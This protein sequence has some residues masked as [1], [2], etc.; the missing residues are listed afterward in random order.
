M[1]PKKQQA[2]QT[3]AGKNPMGAPAAPKMNAS[4]AAAGPVIS[5]NEAM[6]IAESTGKTTAQVM[7]KAVSQGAALGAA[8]VNSFNNNK[9]GPNTYSP[10]GGGNSPAVNKALEQLQALQGLQMNKGTAYAGYS[11]TS[12]P[13][14]TRYDGDGGALQIPGGT[15]FNPIVLP[16]NVISG[17]QRV[18]AGK[19]AAAPAAPAA[20]AEQPKDPYQAWMDSVNA[21]NQAIIDSVNKQIEANASQAQLYMGQIESLMAEMSKAQQQPGGLAS[22]T[23]YA[24]T[25]TT[26]PAAGAKLTTAITARK[27]PSETDLSISPLV[28]NLEGT[29]LNIAI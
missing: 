18:P 17:V 27:K 1:A 2:A 29:G 6:K 16:R 20:P 23:P 25:T 14:T 10:Y 11:T 15:T 4:I 12:T 8:L 22:L 26:D 9:L 13:G 21:S 3:N 19:G 5:K 24:I 7:A 28:G